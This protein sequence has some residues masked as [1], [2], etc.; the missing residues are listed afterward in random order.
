[1]LALVCINRRSNRES[2]CRK[3]VRLK[4]ELQIDR[5]KVQTEMIKCHT[6]GKLV[7]VKSIHQASESP[8]TATESTRYICESCLARPVIESAC[9]LVVVPASICSQW[10]DEI[11]KHTS[12]ATQLKVFT[13][14]NFNKK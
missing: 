2:F 10:I 6:C 8:T 9:T 11:R 7:A 1:M 14:F 5:V 4:G 13:N 12:S 3:N